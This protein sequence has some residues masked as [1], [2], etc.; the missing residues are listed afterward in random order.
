MKYSSTWALH[1]NSVW[2]HLPITRLA[3]RHVALYSIETPILF[4]SQRKSQGWI[5]YHN[6]FILNV[7]S[8]LHKMSFIA[9]RIWQY[10]TQQADFLTRG[11][12]WFLRGSHPTTGPVTILKVLQIISSESD[13]LVD[14]FCATWWCWIFFYLVIIII[15]S[16]FVCLFFFCSQLKTKRA[17]RT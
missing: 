3:P 16:F 4:F 14:A 8:F 1:G 12:T 7:S 15:I 11:L 2:R 6:K 10:S 13:L 5:L 17:I 9:K